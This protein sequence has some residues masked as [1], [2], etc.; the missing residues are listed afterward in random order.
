MRK[1]IEW[2]WEKLDDETARARVIGGWLVLHK[3]HAK[4]NSAESVTF[5]ADRDHEWCVVEPYSEK[6]KVLSSLKASDFDPAPKS[7]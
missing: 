7:A 6:V 4:N 5:V 2:Q 3:T 1:K